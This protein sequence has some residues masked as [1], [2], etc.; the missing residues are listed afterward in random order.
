MS[1]TAE[2]SSTPP[3]RIWREFYQQICIYK[4]PTGGVQR[5]LFVG[6]VH[7]ALN[8]LTAADDHDHVVNQSFACEKDWFKVSH[9]SHCI[10]S[11]VRRVAPTERKSASTI[12]DWLV[13]QDSVGT[14]HSGNING[15]WGL[16]RLLP[17][18][19]SRKRCLTKSL[20]RNLAAL[21]VARWGIIIT[22]IGLLQMTNDHLPLQSNTMNT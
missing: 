2:P 13:S 18:T 5:K 8:Y 10:I 6:T 22:N 4:S 17:A 14:F 7:V 11:K 16:S 19:W 12:C 9:P 15:F 1:R 21:Q 3:S 20:E